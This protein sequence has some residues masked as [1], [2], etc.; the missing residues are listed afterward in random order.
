MN[1]MWRNPSYYRPSAWPVRADR[2]AVPAWPEEP[3]FL[4]QA[5]GDYGDDQMQQVIGTRWPE[6]LAYREAAQP[7][8][9]MPGRDED[10]EN[11]Q[12]IEYFMELYPSQTKTMQ[13]YVEGICDHFD[14]DGSPIYDEIPDRITMRRLRDMVLKNAGEDGTLFGK[15][16]YFGD[17]DCGAA[18]DMAEIL[19]YHE[20]VRRRRQ[21][22]G[23]L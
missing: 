5:F 7:R 19:L 13:R 9:W 16:G 3:G 15:K 21:K 1:N 23:M 8:F 6:N 4:M 18:K 14:Y 20:I 12:D 22:R 10:W 17:P 11:E 2:E